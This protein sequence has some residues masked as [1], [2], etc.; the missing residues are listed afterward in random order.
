MTTSQIMDQTMGEDEM[1]KTYINTDVY[2]HK[3]FETLKTVQL[4]SEKY[5]ETQL[6]SFSIKNVV[7]VQMLNLMNTI[8]ESYT[9]QFYPEIVKIVI[10]L[11]TANDKLYLLFD[12]ACS[13]FKTRA[14]IYSKDNLEKAH[15]LVMLLEQVPLLY[16][17]LTKIEL[18]IITAENEEEIGDIVS[19]TVI[20]DIIRKIDAYASEIL[21]RFA[22]DSIDASIDLDPFIEPV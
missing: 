4:L 15:W 18:S 7:G 13:Y 14:D 3:Y 12:T 17:Q 9:Q 2:Q 8:P 10:D 1:L 21:L 19:N 6:Q 5:L 16:G 11:K 20:K 22:A